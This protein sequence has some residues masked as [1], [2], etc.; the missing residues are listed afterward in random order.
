M[1]RVELRPKRGEIIRP[2]LLRLLQKRQRR[3][4]AARDGCAVHV[5]NHRDQH[6]ITVDGDQVHYTLFTELVDRGLEGGVADGVLV[7]QFVREVV[8]DGLVLLHVRGTPVLRKVFR[9][10][11]VQSR[12]QREAVMRMPLVLRGPV[13]RRHQNREFI[14][15]RR[16]RAPEPDLLAQLPKP[17]GERRAAE[18][19]IERAA[20]GACARYD[21]RTARG[22]DR[23]GHDGIGIRSLRRRHLAQRREFE[24]AHVLLRACASRQQGQP[25]KQQSNRPD[26]H[27]A[28][29]LE[30][31]RQSSIPAVTSSKSASST[32]FDTKRGAQWAI[33][34]ATRGFRD[35][36]FNSTS[37]MKE[38]LGNMSL[39]SSSP[40]GLLD[41]GKS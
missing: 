35:F 22:R 28:F 8:D 19:Y 32:P 9:D 10:S 5:Q 6:V 2:R 27:L 12:L 40:I 20:D 24:A 7:V 15:A 33:A 17:L 36:V 31:T 21:G 16:Q 14:Q 39:H 25:G 4:A 18:V 34:A 41:Q 37:D 26:I 23:A 13:A 11:R 30:V 3:L 29:S 1:Y 38:S